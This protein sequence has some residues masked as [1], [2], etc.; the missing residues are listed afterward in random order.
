MLWTYLKSKRKESS[1]A[2]SKGILNDQ[3]KNNFDPFSGVR[4]FK[5]KSMMIIGL[6]YYTS[7]LLYLHYFAVLAFKDHHQHHINPG[8]I[9]IREGF[10]L[11]PRAHHCIERW[12]VA[13]ID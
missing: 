2:T 5:L 3:T 11:V 7:E 1:T 8:V 12:A 4:M 9:N 6:I 10:V 13:R